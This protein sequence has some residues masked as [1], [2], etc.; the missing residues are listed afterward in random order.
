MLLESDIVSMYVNLIIIQALVRG[1]GEKAQKQVSL[2]QCVWEHDPW[3]SRS[4]CNTGI[5]YM[6]RHAIVYKKEGK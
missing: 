5:H 1:K 2:V 4:H 3:G 6:S